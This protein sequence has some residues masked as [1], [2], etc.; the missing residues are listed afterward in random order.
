MLHAGVALVHNVPRLR[1]CGYYYAGGDVDA[2]AAALHAALRDV[3]GADGADTAAEAARA[4]RR[5]AA[6]ACLREFHAENPV[7]LLAVE[8]LL[9]DVLTT[10]ATQQT[11]I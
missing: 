10:A 5:A 2:A 4:A 1:R 8:L 9:A 3:G 11:T 7:N 6:A